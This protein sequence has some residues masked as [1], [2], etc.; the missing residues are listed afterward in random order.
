MKKQ[1]SKWLYL[2]FILFGLY[3]LFIRKN[4]SESVMFLGVALAFDPFDQNQTW[5]DR[6]VWQ[7]VV[8]ILHLALV[9][10]LFI[11]AISPEF[12]GRVFP[13]YIHH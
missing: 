7:R 6:P 13:G 9:F 1:Y 5:N 2:G 11:M 12:A 3:Q 8:L 10:F 4:F